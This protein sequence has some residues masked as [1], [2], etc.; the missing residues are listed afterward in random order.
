[1]T[2]PL[3]N[4]RL[5]LINNI[6]R[7]VIDE[8]F[9]RVIDT[10]Y[11]EHKEGNITI[12]RFNTNSNNSY[13]LEFIQ[14]FIDC[15]T[16]LDEGVLGDYV[17]GVRTEDFCIIPS[18]DI[19]FVPSEINIEDRDNHELYTQETNRHELFE[20]MGRI[21]YLTKRFIDNNLTYNNY[22]I[23]KNTKQTKLDIYRTMYENVFSNDFTIRE[24]DN[25]NYDEGCY[26]FIKTK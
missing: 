8:S 16:K 17:N 3:V 18:I 13:D 23:G 10:S 26:Y 5:F 24:G 4:E 14:T 7:E 22:V 21:S 2:S 25:P 12:Y 9:D 6:I 19:A 1:M 15:N 11:T 20:L